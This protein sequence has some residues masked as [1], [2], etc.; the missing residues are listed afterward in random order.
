[1]TVYH[2]ISMLSLMAF[3]DNFTFCLHQA[4]KLTQEIVQDNIEIMM[5][6]MPIRVHWGPES[7][8]HKLG[9]IKL[10]C[11]LIA[12]APTWNHFTGK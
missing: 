3:V 9:G 12:L 2:Q 5:E 11:Q 4:L 8:C 1:M 10:L 7:T 6:L